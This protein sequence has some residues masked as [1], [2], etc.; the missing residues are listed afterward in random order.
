LFGGGVIREN[1]LVEIHNALATAELPDLPESLVGEALSRHSMDRS[2]ALPR[3]VETYTVAIRE[4]G[5]AYRHLP[6]GTPPVPRLRSLLGLTVD[7]TKT[8]DADVLIP[9]IR[10][11]LVAAAK[12]HEY[13]DDEEK[14]VDALALRLGIAE[15]T[16]EEI[17]REV[18]GPIVQAAFDAALADGRFSPEEEQR[19]NGLAKK[20]GIKPDYT[21]ESRRV[22]AKFRRL[23]EL[24][25]QPLPVVPTAVRL[26]AKEQCHAVATPTKLCEFRTRT[27]A[28]QY[29]GPSA[30]IR[31]AKGIYFNMGHLFVNRVKDE[32]LHTLDIGTLYVTNQRFL[33][34]G[35][36]K[37]STIPLTRIINA[38]VHADGVVVEKDSGK[39]Q[40][41]L[42]DEIDERFSVVLSRLLRDGG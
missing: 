38:T 25:N 37:T 15:D 36:K 14:A 1:A 41:F 35:N 19:L 7:E 28:V 40:I 3:L 5:L 34:D 17:R 22:L 33:F 20:L 12:D 11:A 4:N 31:L 42:C 10:D 24:E 16:V 18:F 8:A 27:R 9:V 26:K 23:W 21:E 32:A 30:R 29:A 2:R 39:D 13:T 6:D